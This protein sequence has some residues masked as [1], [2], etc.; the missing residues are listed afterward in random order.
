MIVI[1]LV[2]EPAYRSIKI[3]AN[4]KLIVDTC[5][6]REYSGDT[7]NTIVPKLAD[8]GIYIASESMF[9][10]VLREY[11][12]LKHRTNTK[13]PSPK[14]KTPVLEANGPNQVWS[15]DI[16]YLKRDILGIFYYLYLFMDIWSRMIIGW[17]I[18]EYES[19]DI[20][21]DT[22]EHLCHRNSIGEIWLHSDNG[23]PMT[24]GTMLARMEK[25]GVIPSFSRPAVS[26]DNPFSES[27][28]G[29]IKYRPGYPGKFSTKE[30]ADE[31]MTGFVDWYNFKHLHS[32]I[33][34]VTPYQRHTG[35]DVEILKKR[36]DT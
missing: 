31:W 27:L 24:C 16:T 21:A 8:K 6:R 23:S 34:H 15:W 4:K 33:K 2:N 28:F 30:E 3:Y 19:G 32:G 22:L 26:N 9:Y 1:Y 29:I 11:K 25:L 7:P 13:P 10:R 12:L 14:R 18:E 20:A 5:N 17:T 36:E 35:Q